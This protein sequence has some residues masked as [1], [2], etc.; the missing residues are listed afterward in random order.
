ML[1]G[2]PSLLVRLGVGARNALFDVGALPS[3]RVEGLQVV[4]VGHLVVGGAG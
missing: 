1:L 2:P 3:T 4:S